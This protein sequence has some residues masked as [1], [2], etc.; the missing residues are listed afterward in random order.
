MNCC[1]F[2]VFTSYIYCL[3]VINYNSVNVHVVKLYF[4][5][6][7]QEEEVLEAINIA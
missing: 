4:R 1:K 2:G 5:F 3:S 6:T 7:T